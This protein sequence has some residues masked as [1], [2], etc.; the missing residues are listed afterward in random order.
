MNIETIPLP[1]RDLMG[2]DTVPGNQQ[3]QWG[4]SVPGAKPSFN[5]ALLFG[6]DHDAIRKRILIA[7]RDGRDMV[8][9]LVDNG[10]NLDC[11]LGQ[12]RL[13][14]PAHFDPVYEQMVVSGFRRTF[15]S[16]YTW[17]LPASLRGFAR[18]T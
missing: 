4:S 11:S 14:R 13:H 6:I 7:G 16:N 3:Q 5:R 12:G 10:D 8:L 2:H 18:I 1:W 9:I 17:F 15:F